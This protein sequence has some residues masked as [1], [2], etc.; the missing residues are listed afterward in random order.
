MCSEVLADQLQNKIITLCRPQ[1]LFLISI[2]CNEKLF[3]DMTVLF[4]NVV[5]IPFS[6][7]ESFCNQFLYAFIF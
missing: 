7:T 4:Y 5:V 3:N 2:L 1:K 6:I